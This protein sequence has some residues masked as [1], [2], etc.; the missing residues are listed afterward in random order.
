MTVI[1]CFNV[2]FVCVFMLFLYAIGSPPSACFGALPML[3][4]YALANAGLAVRAKRM[5]EWD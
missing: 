2:L 1:Y 4:F 3:V 5:G